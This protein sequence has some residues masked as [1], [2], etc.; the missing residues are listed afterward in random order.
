MG[1]QGSSEIRFGIPI[2]I[3]QAKNN[4]TV[5]LSRDGTGIS[6]HDEQPLGFDTPLDE[7]LLH[8]AH[9][10]FGEEPQVMLGYAFTASSPPC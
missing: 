1:T 10:A 3:E 4:A 7:G 8:Q 5:S 6:G 9:T 2:S